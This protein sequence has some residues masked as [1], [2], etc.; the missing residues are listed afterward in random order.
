MTTAK[1][2]LPTF[3]VP[4]QAGETTD[5]TF[6]EVGHYEETKRTTTFDNYG[7][8][9]QLIQV[10]TETKRGFVKEDG[11]TKDTPTSII[12]L[13]ETMIVWEDPKMPHQKVKHLEPEEL[14]V[15]WHH[16]KCKE[17]GQCCHT[18]VTKITAAHGRYESIK[19]ME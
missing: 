12:I 4:T 14:D 10:N 11:L 16:E 18:K 1:P 6:D 13:K 9:G 15:T 17:T 7:S 5:L 3:Y 2:Q 19:T 8:V